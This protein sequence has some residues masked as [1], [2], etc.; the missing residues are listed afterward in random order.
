M[1]WDHYL[2]LILPD[3]NPVLITLRR[4]NTL[5][6][7]FDIQEKVEKLQALSKQSDLYALFNLLYQ[8]GHIPYRQGVPLEV[9][10][11]WEELMQSDLGGAI[12]ALKAELDPYLN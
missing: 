12:E 2:E 7:A 1:T 8:K 5:A 3:T 10:K 6:D 4:A 9:K 11:K